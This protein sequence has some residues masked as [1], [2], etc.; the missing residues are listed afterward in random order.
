MTNKIIA[1]LG[2]SGVGKS[3]VLNKLS[4]NLP[5]QH[6]QASAI[7]KERRAKLENQTLS[8]DDL[9]SFSINDNQQLLVDGFKEVVQASPRLAILDGHSAIET[10]S[11]VVLIEPSVFAAIGIAHLIF[12][13]DHPS[14]IARRRDQDLSRKRPPASEQQLN[15]LQDT[16][17]LQASSIA[18][19]LDIMMTVL[20]PSH[21][22]QLAIVLANQ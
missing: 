5:F 19:E 21:A 15:T 18:R 4:S 3:T 22:G 14:A 20:Q 6:L 8:N 12:L 9:R 16:A 13:V 17:L 10:P 2:V 1:L 11:G 7:I